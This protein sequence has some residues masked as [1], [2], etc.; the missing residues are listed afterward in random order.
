MAGA[1]GG[2]SLLPWYATGFRGDQLEEDLREIA[3]LSTRYGCT[4]YWVFRGRDDRYKFQQF[5]LWERHVD[6]ERYWEGE[7]MSYFRAAHSG[8]YQI[9][10]LYSWWDLSA[11]GGLEEAAAQ[12]AA[13]GDALAKQSSNGA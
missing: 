12:L 5:N 7:D 8:W 3:A 13:N 1:G 6:W 2:I 11:S 4:Q 9:P 10:L